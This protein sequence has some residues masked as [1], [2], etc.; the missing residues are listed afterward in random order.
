ML[1]ELIEATFSSFLSNPWRLV[2]DPYVF[3]SVL[4]LVYTCW[5]QWTFTISPLLHPEKPPDIPYWIPFVGH[6]WTMFGDSASFV[7]RGIKHFKRAY[8]PFTIRVLGDQLYVVTCPDD[9]SNVYKKSTIFS[10]HGHMDML[11]DGWGLSK[12]ARKISWRKPLPGELDPVMSK[13]LNPQNK[14]LIEVIEDTY[15]MQ[16][17]PG[18]RLD[19]MMSSVIDK[20]NASLTWDK[21]FGPFVLD[22]STESR[23][24]SVK[25]MCRT[26]ITEATTR[27]MFGDL[28]FQYE[29][30]IV[31]QL[32][33]TND[34]A[35][36][37]VFNFPSILIP[38]L[39]RARKR[40]DAAVRACI[41]T[42][43][44]FRQGEGWAVRRVIQALE[45]FQMD[46][47]SRVS[48]LLM[49]LWASY[50]NT[51]SA[52]FWTASYILYN[53]DLVESLRQET[54]PALNG[55][56][57]DT[58]YLDKH[59]PLLNSTFYECLRLISG[60]ASIRRVN[61]DVTMSGMRLKAGNSVLIPVRELHY[62]SSVWGK[63]SADFDP[64]R[65][66]NRP[67]LTN[68][69]GYRPFGGGVSYC[70]G[71]HL[72]KA[73]I[74]SFVVALIHR[75]DISIPTDAKG[76]PQPFPKMDFTR[77]SPGVSLCED[78]QDLVLDLRP[79]KM[80]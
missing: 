76:R 15:K 3:F 29:P 71:R 74:C 44:K 54:L 47:E 65:F 27:T 20:I 67:N 80:T 25:D 8:K 52:A 48:L 22:S 69:S 37:Y 17:L 59:C 57:I 56:A 2:S 5:W 49:V 70:A 73:E 58:K 14:C 42:P 50:S 72:A 7:S 9:V 41:N 32:S 55:S 40:I 11:L 13:E 31:E 39:H 26:V 21:L 62:N 66:L 23:R 4:G 38:K 46:E 61:E 6:S 33:I 63:T 75:F 51:V 60:S 53:P 78:G 12:E 45:L 28:I 68:H 64:T 34:K 16:L 30:S 36:A 43:E 1:L 77:P 19:T 35:W 24:V 79:R 18:E 10:W